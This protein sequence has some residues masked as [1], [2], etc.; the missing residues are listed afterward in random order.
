MSNGHLP[1]R[2]IYVRQ[3]H[4]T[5]AVRRDSKRC[6]IATAV[7]DNIPWATYILVDSQSIRFSNY[8]SGERYVYLTP[9]SV[10]QALLDFD[11]G[12]VVKPFSI[13]MRLGYIRQMRVRQGNGVKPET[14]KR[15]NHAAKSGQPKR[16]MAARYREHGIR[17]KHAQERG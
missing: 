7:H 5:H 11:S 9:P 12:V 16:Y 15:K 14:P 2:R 4:I 8:E 10:Q 3:D 1:L 6:M 13:N 17:V